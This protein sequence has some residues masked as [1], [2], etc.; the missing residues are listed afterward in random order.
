MGTNSARGGFTAAGGTNRGG[1]QARFFNRAQGGR[2]RDFWAT[3]VCSCVD[4][5]LVLDPTSAGKSADP[6]TS[7]TFSWGM[8]CTREHIP[9]PALTSATTASAT[10]SDVRVGVV[11]AA[12]TITPS[13]DGLF[14]L[15][16]YPTPAEAHTQLR[17][18]GAEGVRV[19]SPQ[20]IYPFV[21]ALLGSN[22][23]NGSW[24]EVDRDLFRQEL[25]KTEPTNLL[26]RLGEIVSFPST[27]DAALTSRTTLNFERGLLPLIAYLTF[28][29]VLKSPVK[30]EVNALYSVILNNFDEFV[31]TVT[32]ALDDYLA[33]GSVQS[34]VP[35]TRFFSVAESTPLQIHSLY[36]FLKPLAS[37]LDECLGRWRDAVVQ[38][39]QLPMLVE[40]LES[41]FRYWASAITASPPTFV[42]SLASDEELCLFVIR[43]LADDIKK[44]AVRAGR[45]TLILDAADVDSQRTSTQPPRA[46][47]GALAHLAMTFQ[48]PSGH[49]N[50]QPFIK[51]IAVAPTSEELVDGADKVR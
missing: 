51:D 27:I 17:K 45:T 29:A 4:C 49:G 18:M 42:D 31:A 21:K 2:C 36:Q 11:D 43:R 30:K 33:R 20:Q 24:T 25:A 13:T 38:A 19:D 15:A 22:K 40:K 6:F 5:L 44:V 1:F 26:L 37:V 50:D 34:T 10:P 14:V 28:D 47:Q 39:P 23:A 32:G 46:H 41:T 12:A 3:G 8:A 7:P 35:V 9:N 48:G 16:R